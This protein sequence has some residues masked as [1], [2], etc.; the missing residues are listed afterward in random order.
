VYINIS[1]TE[2][3]DISTAKNKKLFSQ[4]APSIL[5]QNG[6]TRAL[7]GDVQ[8]EDVGTSGY[9]AFDHILWFVGNAKQAASYYVTRMGFKHVAY[10]SPYIAR[11]DILCRK[12]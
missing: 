8:A 4:M 3:T 2:T 5:T 6:T 11:T 10:V 7:N 12:V 9:Q 1:K